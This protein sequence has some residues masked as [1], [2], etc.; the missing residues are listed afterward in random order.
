MRFIKGTDLTRPMNNH[1]NRGVRKQVGRHMA[2]RRRP[3]R[4]A[5]IARVRLYRL[6]LAVAERMLVSERQ[7]MMTLLEQQSETIQRQRDTIEKLQ[8]SMAR[9][10]LAASKLSEQMEK[11]AAAAG[12]D[13]RFE[14]ITMQ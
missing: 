3:S 14:T 7:Q 13:V 6:Q 9:L 1:P 12:L 5:L 2:R 8:V 10:E 4:R 11:L